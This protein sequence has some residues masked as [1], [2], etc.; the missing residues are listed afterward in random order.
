MCLN[1]SVY[2][3]E[4]DGL[5]DYQPSL[6]PHLHGKIVINSCFIIRIFQLHIKFYSLFFQRSFNVLDAGHLNS[7]FAKIIIYYNRRRN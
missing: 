5:P 2:N 7:N 3:T 4:H 1:V 6:G